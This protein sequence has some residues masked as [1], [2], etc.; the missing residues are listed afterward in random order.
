MAAKINDDNLYE[1]CDLLSS[2]NYSPNNN[3]ISTLSPILSDF[4]HLPSMFTSAPNA[5]TSA[6]G[7][8]FAVK[9]TFS[10]SHGDTGVECADLSTNNDPIFA[11]LLPTKSTAFA[12]TVFFNSF[13]L[14]VGVCEYVKRSI[15][16]SSFD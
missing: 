3:S 6:Q 2:P 11:T 4:G 15:L 1:L 8:K 5:K 13:L 12:S 10:I 14:S 16:S 7:A 9:P